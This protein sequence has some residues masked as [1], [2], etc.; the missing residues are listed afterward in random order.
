M[1]EL[2][3][4][5]DIHMENY[6]GCIMDQDKNIVR[7]LSFPPTKKGAD[8]FVSGMPIKA[9]AIEACSMWRAAMKLFEGY[10]VK[11]ASPKKTKDIAG[12][13][14]T[15]KVD[16]KTLANLLRTNYLPEIY[17]PDD[18]T[19]QLRDLARHKET[20]TNMRADIQRKIKS[21]MLRQGIKYPKKLWSIKGVEWVSSLEEPNIQNLLRLYKNFVNEEREAKS[22]INKIANNS[23]ITNLLMTMPGVAGFS[24]V[25]IQE[26]IADI[27][28]FP[29]P[30]HLVMY[31]GLCP[32]IY[33]TGNTEFSVRNN[34]VNKHLK[35]I[36][37]E[38]SGR[39]AIMKGTKFQ[40]HYAKISKRRGA[41]VARRSTARKMLTII[42]HMLKNNEPYACKEA[43][44]PPEFNCA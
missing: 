17:I 26:E 24:S 28:R 33:Q 37:T 36:I 22:R 42:W 27:D 3:A 38:C 44:A 8:A 30:K 4:G 16:A 19:L 39:A 32:G 18:K 25:M 6:V 15:D 40:R 21:Y 14:K 41:K 10:D 12:K 43:R 9:I 5:V 31:A 20:L 7:E 35:W 1:Q 23:R 34:A 29:T 11:V 2:Y 13:K